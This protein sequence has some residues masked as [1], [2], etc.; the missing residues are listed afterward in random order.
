MPLAP[1]LEH[2]PRYVLQLVPPNCGVLYSLTVFDVEQVVDFQNP[3]VT[4][5]SLPKTDDNV[6]SGAS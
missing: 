2:W 5:A 6:N 4:E 1:L 3:T